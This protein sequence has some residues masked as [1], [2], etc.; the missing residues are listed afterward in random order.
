MLGEQPKEET[1]AGSSEDSPAKS[2]SLGA[3]LQPVVKS[4]SDLIDLDDTKGK[5]KRKERILVVVG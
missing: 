5:T 4:E 1:E 3:W 2:E